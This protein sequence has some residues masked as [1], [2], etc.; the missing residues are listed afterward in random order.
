M[1]TIPDLEERLRAALSA[2]ADTVQ[3]EDLT[4]RSWLAA[5]LQSRRHAWLLSS[6]AVAACVA[7]VLVLITRFIPD[8]PGADP[9]PGPSKIDLTFPDDVGRDWPVDDLSTSPRLDLDGDGRKERVEFHSEP[10]RDFDGR[11]RIQTRLTGTGEES[12]GVYQVGEFGT[13]IG[14]S[15]WPPVDL[16]GDGDQELVMWE[17]TGGPGGLQLRVFDLREGL[18]VESPPSRPDLLGNGQVLVP[19]SETD[20]YDLRYLQE[21][22]TDGQDLVTTRSRVAFASHGLDVV[23]PEQYVADVFVWRLREDGALV[24][25]PDGCRLVGLDGSRECEPGDHDTVPTLTDSEVAGADETVS[26]DVGYR[27]RARIDGSTLVAEGMSGD[28]LSTDLGEIDEPRLLRAAPDLLRGDGVVVVVTSATDPALLR[29]FAQNGRGTEL[30]E[31]SDVGDV[32]LGSGVVDGHETR[33]WLTVDGTITTA[34]NHEGREW[35]VWSW[36]WEGT[37]TMAAIPRGRFCLDD[38]GSPQTVRHC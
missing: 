8:N 31:V 19:G 4:Q 2:Q 23:R 13:T 14:V 11:V 33:S 12:Y 27:Y 15:A 26:F 22:T 10:T 3:P 1:S 29:V 36:M 30:L 35:D 21:T 16:D 18:L 5:P 28:S 25:E 9:A 34:V 32:A 24:P 6:L 38:I 17:D 37:G 7:L 20:Y